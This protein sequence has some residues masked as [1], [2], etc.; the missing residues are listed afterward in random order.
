MITPDTLQTDRRVV[1]TESGHVVWHLAG[2]GPPLVLIHGGTGSWTHW[3]RA[4]PELASDYRLLMPDLPGF[5]ES[6]LPPGLIGPMDL[7]S[8]VH[9]SLDTLLPERPSLAVAG[10]SF[11]S[12]V[13]GLLAEKMPERIERLILVGASGLGLPGS[14]RLPLQRWR[15]LPVAER[16]PVH[17]HNLATLMLFDA[18]AIDRETIALQSANAEA[19]RLDSRPISAKSYLHDS[20]RRCPQT[21]GAIWGKADAVA[22]YDMA[23]RIAI[24]RDVDPHCPVTV[25]PDAGHWVAHERPAAFA[26][27]IRS[28][29]NT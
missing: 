2:R 28:M 16:A 18:A 15:N 7:A 12:L 21:L 3:L 1:P 5:G 23:D 10:F 26:A 20:L 17:R 13:S 27:A 22:R 25:I 24:L 14:F 6:T 4:I 29:L 11:G 8:A 9:E 19:V